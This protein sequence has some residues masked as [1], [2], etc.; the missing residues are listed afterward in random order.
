MNAYCHQV[1][2]EPAQRSAPRVA[3]T[4]I[5]EI[6]LR[7]VYGELKAYPICERAKIFA[8]MQCTKT[9]TRSAL[10]HVLAL[11][12]TI[13]ELD[14]HGNPSRTYSGTDRVGATSNLPAVR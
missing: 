11:G 3:P 8:S 4:Q 12:Y 7:S 2:L 6:E 9:L 14:R 1:T 5:I 10:A 13:V